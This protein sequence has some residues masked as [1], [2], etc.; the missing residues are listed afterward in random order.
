MYAVKSKYITDHWFHLACSI[1]TVYFYITS[2]LF[3]TVFFFS[4]LIKLAVKFEFSWPHNFCTFSWGIHF[5]AEGLASGMACV[6]GSIIT[7]STSRSPHVLSF[8][9]IY[10]CCHTD[11]MD[12]FSSR[13]INAPYCLMNTVFVFFVLCLRYSIQMLKLYY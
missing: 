1:T 7:R 2:N 10:V 6:C 5:K 12:C 3:Q 4:K 8:P 9:L 13:Q 11:W